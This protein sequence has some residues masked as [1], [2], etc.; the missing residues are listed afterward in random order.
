[1]S[2]IEHIFIAPAAGAPQQSVDAVKAV[3]GEGLQGD[4]YFGVREHRGQHLTLIEAEVLEAFLAR[5]GRPLGWALSRRNLIT[6]GVSLNALVGRRFQIGEVELIGVETCEPCATLGRSLADERLSA[7]EAVRYFVGRGGLRADI[8][9][10][11]W[12][13][14]GDAIVPLT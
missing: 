6:R 3:A 2:V 9:R 12:I 14:C 11:G 5:D 10:S 4:R 8:L 1:M 13:A 7:A